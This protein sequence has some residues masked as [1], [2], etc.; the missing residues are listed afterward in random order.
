MEIKQ[1]N[2]TE[3]NN[4]IN[5]EIKN[6]NEDPDRI[7]KAINGNLIDL[8]WDDHDALVF[9][10]LNNKLLV[11]YS[12]P[13]FKMIY[14][15]ILNGEYNS[16][17]IQNMLNKIQN[18]KN[19]K[20][21]E[22]NAIQEFLFN[23]SHKL[24]EKLKHS[25]R[26]WTDDK[27]ISFWEYPEN[28]IVLFRILREIENKTKLNIL[29]NNYL[30]E[31]YNKNIYETI[32]IPIEQYDGKYFI[33]IPN[34]PHE[35]PDFKWKEMGGKK[36][37][38]YNTI[39]HNK[40]KEKGTKSKTPAEYNFITQ[41]NVAENIYDNILN[42]VYDLLEYNIEDSFLSSYDTAKKYAYEN[43]D[44]VA[45]AFDAYNQNPDNIQNEYAYDNY[46][47]R[48]E[49]YVD[50]YNHLKNQNVVEIYRLVKLNSL[51]NLD[52]KNIGMHWSFEKSG[53]GD[54]GGYHPK[55]IHNN[56]NAKPYVLTAYVN[57]KDIDWVYGFNSFIWYDE[58]QWECALNKNTKVIITHIN[59]KE[60]SK[61][62]I[63]Y[64]GDH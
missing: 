23:Y 30:I 42:E 38:P 8:N 54:Y 15:V 21:T 27:I 14:N 16:I 22:K 59:D 40:K 26:L 41:K 29:N 33:N 55:Q 13:H 2:G 43:I 9:G 63:A 7:Y 57:P 52:L 34:K 61:N 17:L 50:K 18:N 53:V 56:P 45:D 62:L 44:D 32:L 10:Y 25:G 6:L 1:F 19:I 64:V 48:I 51:K 4:I 49:L 36:T 60:L 20:N 47:E 35:I 31:V 24:R 3:I 39:Y 46:I 28:K 11:D 58:D 37:T 5:D 12:V